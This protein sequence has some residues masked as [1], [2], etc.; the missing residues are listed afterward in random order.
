MQSSS[1]YSTL[2]AHPSILGQRE[3]WS[4]LTDIV[5]SA[6]FFEPTTVVLANSRTNRGTSRGLPSFSTLS[7]FWLKARAAC[8]RWRS[9]PTRTHPAK[10]EPLCPRRKTLFRGLRRGGTGRE[11]AA[12]P[13]HEQASSGARGA[14]GIEKGRSLSGPGNAARGQGVVGACSRGFGTWP[15]CAVQR[16]VVEGARFTSPGTPQLPP[17]S[18]LVHSSRGGVCVRRCRLSTPDQ[19]AGGCTPCLPASVLLGPR[20]CAA[21]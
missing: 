15:R 1:P 21:A 11:R 10:E 16:P 13:A 2:L 8:W 20:R 19:G 17:T 12:R 3:F 6:A 9:E 5:G 18:V 7:E 14:S 4:P